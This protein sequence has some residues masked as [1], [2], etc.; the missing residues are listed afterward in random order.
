LW[1]ADRRQVYDD[2]MTAPLRSPGIGPLEDQEALDDLRGASNPLEFAVQ[3]PGQACAGPLALIARY[4]QAGKE[5]RIFGLSGWLRSARRDANPGGGVQMKTRNLLR[6]VRDA[7]H[8]PPQYHFTGK[9]IP[10]RAATPAEQ[11]QQAQ[12][13]CQIKPDV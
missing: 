11:T 12:E 3:S 10:A 4:T 9:S 7:E 5:I 13:S 8:F 2:L 6:S 1:R